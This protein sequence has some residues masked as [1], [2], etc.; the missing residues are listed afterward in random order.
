MPKL[1]KLDHACMPNLDE[2]LVLS[3]AQFGIQ[4]AATT[5]AKYAA[6]SAQIRIAAA[7]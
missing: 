3:E 7:K 1:A 6:T 2:S 4:A 5:G